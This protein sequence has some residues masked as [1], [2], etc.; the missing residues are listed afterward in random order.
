MPFLL[1]CGVCGYWIV[2]SRFPPV[3]F[4]VLIFAG[5][6]LALAVVRSFGRAEI[7]G[8]MRLPG[9]LLVLGITALLS[10]LAGG[11]FVTAWLPLACLA[12]AAGLFWPRPWQAARPWARPAV[13]WVSA[14]AILLLAAAAVFEARRAA[15]LTPAQRVLLTEGTPV[16]GAEL[17]KITECAPLQ[18]VIRGAV[19]DRKLVEKAAGKA[20]EVCEPGDLGRFLAT[21]SARIRRVGGE[22]AWKAEVL[23]RARR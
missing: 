8:A 13:G 14:I 21:E 11:P 7:P 6:F 10:L 18:E 2:W 5:W 16:A 23:E 12:G 9:A 17:K 19:S 4:W 1:A 3:T 20:R 15:R 22:G